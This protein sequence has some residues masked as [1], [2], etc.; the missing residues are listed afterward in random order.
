MSGRTVL[1]LWILAATRS[2]WQTDTHE[3]TLV[4]LPWIGPEQ[5]EEAFFKG[6]TVVDSST[7]T[8]HLTELIRETA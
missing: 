4:Y 7:V 5:R 2:I 8:T 3:P 6:Y 1:W